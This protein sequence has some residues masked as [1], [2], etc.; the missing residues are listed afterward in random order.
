MSDGAGEQ[1]GRNSQA[2][3]SQTWRST[4]SHQVAQLRG[5]IAQAHR[6]L[7]VVLTSDHTGHIRVDQLV[8]TP[9]RQ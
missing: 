6:A 2:A 4:E 5:G 8:V 7:A 1:V 9:I 3:E